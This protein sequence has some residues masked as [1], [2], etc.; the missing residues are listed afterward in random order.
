MPRGVVIAIEVLLVCATLACSAPPDKERHQAEGAISAARAADAATY[1]PAA[2]AAAEAS[3]SHYDDAV[4]QHDYRQALRLAVEARDGAYDAARQSANAKAAAQGE[5]ERLVT[6][7][8]ALVQQADARLR[9]QTAPRL[10]GAV[11]ERVRTA[12]KRATS[13]LQEARADIARQQYRPAT[14]RLAPII[15]ILRADLQSPAPAAPRRGR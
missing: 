11:A 5:A 14:D 1:A 7:L 12:V 10:S 15:A 4:A 13:A 9:G 8:D 6:E 3:L 2:L